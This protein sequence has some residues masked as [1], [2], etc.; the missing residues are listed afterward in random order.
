MPGGLAWQGVWSE[1][2][3]RLVACGFGER[4]EG[5]LQG[6]H[7]AVWIPAKAAFLTAEQDLGLLTSW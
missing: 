4:P 6:V 5:Q 1:G 7:L 2:V 3:V